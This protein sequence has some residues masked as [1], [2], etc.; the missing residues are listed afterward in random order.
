MILFRTIVTQRVIYGS[1]RK[2]CSGGRR[3]H[4][5]R[6]TEKKRRSFRD[7]DLGTFKEPVGYVIGETKANDIWDK[8]KAYHMGALEESKI[9]VEMELQSTKM[10]GKET[11]NNYI[12][13]GR[14]ISAKSAALGQVMSEKHHSNN[15]APR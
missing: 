13:R 7:N 10:R 5:R 8:L 4:I 9:D 1:R 3:R 6:L 15:T 11:V 2:S 14:G 12:T